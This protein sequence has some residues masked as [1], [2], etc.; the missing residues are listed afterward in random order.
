MEHERIYS[1][2]SHREALD[3]LVRWAETGIDKSEHRL[4]GW[5]WGY[6]QQLDWARRKVQQEVEKALEEVK[7]VQR[8]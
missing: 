4:N 7:H 5:W 3:F 1:D 8:A 6:R 2:C